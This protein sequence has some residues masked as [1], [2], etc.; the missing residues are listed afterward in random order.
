[1]TSSKL[2]A[3]TCSIRLCW[4]FWLV[5]LLVHQ[6]ASAQTQEQVLKE[7]K[8]WLDTYT[9][10][11]KSPEFYDKAVTELATRPEFKS[12]L[13]DMVQ[14]EY[15]QTINIPNKELDYMAFRALGALSLRSDLTASEQKIFTDEMERLMSG[16]NADSF[17]NGSINLLAHYPSPEHENLVLRVLTQPNCTD[18]T[19]VV[20]FKAL[21]VIGGARSLETLQQ[22]AA[23]QKKRGSSLWFL[24]ELADSIAVLETRLKQESGGRASG[25][26]L[27]NQT[28]KSSAPVKSTGAATAETPD[29]T[30]DWRVLLLRLVY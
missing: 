27:A 26:P 15:F 14:Q 24:P 2:S 1:M 22:V 10:D 20:A 11:F 4:A 8:G 21:S 6:P 28:P 7:L 30:M 18:S 23:R 13:M 16:P 5:L 25:E 9:S 29:G 12:M 19:M 17:V 3:V